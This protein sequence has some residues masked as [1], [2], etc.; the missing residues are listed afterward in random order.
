MGEYKFN[1]TRMSEVLN[2]LDDMSK[3]LQSV[4]SSDVALLQSINNN[5]TGD[6]VKGT[7]SAYSS[8]IQEIVQETQTLMAEMA[9]YLQ[10]QLSQYTSTEKSAVESLQDIKNI[11]GGLEGGAQ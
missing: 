5:I 11:L 3:Q 4:N 2:R 9:E 7:L 1:A 6:E 8:K 10:G